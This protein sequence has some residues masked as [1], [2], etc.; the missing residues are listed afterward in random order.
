MAFPSLAEP[1]G[2]RHLAPPFPPHSTAPTLHAFWARRS[3]TGGWLPY[4]YGQLH[5]HPRMFH[6]LQLKIQTLALQPHSQE[7][8]PSAD[9]LTPMLVR[10]PSCLSQVE[11]LRS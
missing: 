4:V 5:L 10:G 9:R 7:L 2:P 1:L 3:E 11:L 6:F 8:P